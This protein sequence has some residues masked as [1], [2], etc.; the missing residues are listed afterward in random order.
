MA[1]TQKSGLQDSNYL[2]TGVTSDISALQNLDALAA[3]TLTDQYVTPDY[4]SVVDPTL[5]N[6][7]QLQD[8]LGVNWTYD[9]DTIQKIYNDATKAGYDVEQQ[10]G[11][12]AKYYKLL[13]DAQNTALDTIR[14]QYGSAVASGANKGM[15]AANMLSAVLGTTQE[16]NE[17]AY[18]LAVDKQTR[19]NTY[20]QQLAQD[21]KD[22]LSY[23]NDTASSIASLS[24][25]LYNDDIQRQTAELSY[26][27]GINTD[28]AGVM[29]NKYTQDANVLNNLRT[30]QA[31]IINNNTSSI[32]QIQSAIA[33]ANAQKY[34]ADQSKNSTTTYAGGYSVT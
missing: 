2:E 6:V 30:A 11:A 14:Q 5:R 17:N 18:Q 26:N 25:Q 21:A 15:Q 23:S 32:A 29:A 12:N 3:N 10:S 16:A 4:T 33:A 31:G 13:A 7:Q 19:A 27:Q 24:R 22:A 20:A 9:L 28:Y 1:L 34:A 8:Q